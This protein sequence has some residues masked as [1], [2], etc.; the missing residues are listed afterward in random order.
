VQ[1]LSNHALGVDKAI[2]YVALELEAYIILAMVPSFQ[3]SKFSREETHTS[4]HGGI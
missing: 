4:V 1:E 3:V 2:L